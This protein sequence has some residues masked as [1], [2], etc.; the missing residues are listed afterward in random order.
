MTAEI[1]QLKTDR[2]EPRYVLARRRSNTIEPSPKA[3]LEADKDIYALLDA[4]WEIVPRGD[5]K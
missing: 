5:P 2:P 4:G 1:V 3:L